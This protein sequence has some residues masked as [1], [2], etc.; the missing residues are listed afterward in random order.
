MPDLALD[1]C[2]A[3]VRDAHHLGGGSAVF[4]IGKRRAVKHDA[5]KSQLQRLDAPLKRQS[6][7][8][9]HD[10]RH[11]GAFCRRDDRRGDE[12]QIAVGQ[13]HL[14]RPDDD[15]RRKRLCRFDRGLQHVGV[16]GVEK[17][18]GIVFLLRFAE[19]GI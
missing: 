5:R 10:H 3:G 17:P 7:V 13:Q 6:G 14:C 9:V 11:G 8:I 4:G 12:R 19:N 15:G 1:R 18:D 2:A 16:G